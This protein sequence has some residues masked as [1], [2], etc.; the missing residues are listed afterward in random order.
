MKTI[1]E[2]ARVMSTCMALRLIV[3]YVTIA[4]AVSA[5]GEVKRVLEPLKPGEIVARG[6]LK[7]QL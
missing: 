1:H 4:I 3:S 5:R 6:L 7:G 2:P